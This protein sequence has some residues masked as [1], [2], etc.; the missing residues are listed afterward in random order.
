M[1]KK[2]TPIDRQTLPETTLPLI[3]AGGKDPEVP[4]SPN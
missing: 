1:T 3:V 2:K 4:V